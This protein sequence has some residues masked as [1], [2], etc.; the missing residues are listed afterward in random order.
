M[1]IPRRYVFR[2][3][4]SAFGGYLYRPDSVVF[5]VP[6]ASSLTVS[7]GR[8]TAKVPGQRW[9]LASFDR[10]ETFAEGLFDEL[11]KASQSMRVPTWTPHE[12]ELHPTTTAWAEIFGLAIGDGATRVTV[13]H[14]RAHMLS[15]STSVSRDTSI[16][17]DE[18]TTIEGVS[19][20]GRPLVIELDKRPFQDHTTRSKLVAALDDERYA[21]EYGAQFFLDAPVEGDLVPRRRRLAN[22]DLI[23]G[24]IVRSIRWA[25][26]VYPGAT[27]DGN[28]V[29]VPDFGR[30]YVGEVLIG[31]A[32]RRLTMVRF[33]LGSPNA[34]RA[35]GSEVQSN[36]SWSP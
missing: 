24:T 31:E 18:T 26:D 34:G 33:D 22:C 35:S 2:G 12:E 5:D 3:N 23:Y 9:K 6:G 21:K 1:P 19:V 10:A 8:S 15:T 27:I 28:M 4:A 30:I 14:A 17:L 32:E 7:G 16:H 36:G 11:Q 25:G 20:G 13:E 29:V